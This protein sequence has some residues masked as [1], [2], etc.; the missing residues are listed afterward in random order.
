MD[1]D[2]VVIGAGFAGLAYA[3]ELAGRRSEGAGA[4]EEAA[5]G[6]A[7]SHHRHPG[8]GSA[9]RMG[10]A[11][12]PGPGNPA[13][14]GVRTEP[15][16]RRGRS[17]TTISSWLRI[18]RDCSDGL[19]EQTRETGVEI[20]NGEDFSGARRERGHWV[21]EE[22]G[23]YCRFL[24]GAD[25]ARSPV[26]KLM[27]LDR[28]TRYLKGVEYAYEPLVEAELS[29][30]CFVDP[31]FRSRL[32]RVGVAGSRRHAGRPGMPQDALGR[33]SRIHP[34]PSIPC[35]ACRPAAYWRSGAGSFR[36]GACCAASLARA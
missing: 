9:G 15:A 21:L 10:G 32:H 1:Y 7:H 6:A 28:N 17:G 18:R 26:A 33:S 8:Q 30:H 4:G 12:A 25:G 11:R 20:R 16:L 5:G 3:R 14:A 35:S 19:Q 2:V 24:V 29:L 34:A 31:E 22:S 27:G 36:S 13:G 23:T